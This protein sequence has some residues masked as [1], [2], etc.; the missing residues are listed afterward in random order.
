MPKKR[1]QKNK[2]LGS[3]FYIFCEGEK[4]EPN[5]FNGYLEYFHSAIRSLHVIKIEPTKENAPHTLVKKAI[6]KKK[7]CPDGDIFWVVYDRE[8]KQGNTEKIHSQA[9]E[10]A[11]EHNIH[12]ALSNICFEL[13]LL[14]HFQYT[15]KPYD[16][17]DELIKDKLKAK[18]PNYE[19]GNKEVFNILKDKIEQACTNARRM[20]TAT[21][22]A[23]DSSWT[24]PYQ[25][26]PYTNVHELLEYIDEFCE[27]HKK[28]STTLRQ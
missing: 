4:T 5:Y 8:S 24:K 1:K 16:N 13:W 28:N 21:Q 18:L 23:A 27:E 15:T 9:D 26:N 10:N 6:G 19:K 22:N 20:N 2:K 12:I 14:L 25:W 3:V 17:C 11:K 7:K